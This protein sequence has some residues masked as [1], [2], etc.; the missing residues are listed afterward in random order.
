MGTLFNRARMTVSGTPGTGTITLGA[1]VS[2]AFFTFAEAGVPNA[3]V[4]SYVIED[5]SNV[6]IGNGTYTASGTT[7][8]RDTVT[9][10]KIAGV[11]G[12]TKV[13][14]T[15]AAVV[16]IDAL[17]DDIIPYIKRT[18]SV[19]VTGT[20]FAVQ[21]TVNSYNTLYNYNTQVVGLWLGGTGDPA[22]YYQ[23][24]VHQFTNLAATATWLTLNSGGATFNLPVVGSPATLDGKQT[25]ASVAQEA[26]GLSFLSKVITAN[27]AYTNSTAVQNW[28]PSGGT[29]TPEAATT[30]EFEGQLHVATT[31]TTTA[32]TISLLFG[33]T[34]TLTSINYTA[35][36]WHAVVNTT[37]ST[38]TAAIVNLTTVNQATATVVTAASGTTSAL[39]TTIKVRG[40]IRVNGAGTLIPQWSMSA[41]RGAGTILANTFFKLRKIGSNTVV[42]QGN[43]A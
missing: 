13:T 18:A 19:S 34:A 16:Y 39:V 31:S 2:G 28:F 24:T 25:V 17:A 23:N 38:A 35:E 5:G 10:S 37:A 40:I 21:D 12:T 8:S 32:H 7:L 33:G 43:W 14:L 9:A 30:Y 4:V 15:S 36:A 22:N 41:A 3:T 1:A 29:L 6:E 20:P 26:F 27:V 42:N 11:A